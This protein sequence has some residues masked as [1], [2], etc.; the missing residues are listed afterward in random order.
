M[1]RQVVFIVLC[2]AFQPVLALEAPAGLHFDVNSYEVLGDNPLSPETIAK[3]LKPYLGRH[4]GLDGLSSAVEELERQLKQQGDSFHRVVVEPQSLRDGVVRLRMLEFKLGTIIVSG[5]KNFSAQ[6]IKQS[7]PS[8][9]TG[10]APNTRL[11]SQNLAIANEH[12]DKTMQMIFKEGEAQNTVDI[13]L[14]VADKSPHTRYAKLAN[15]G[16]EQTGEFR[17]GLGYQYSNLFDKDHIAS[18]NFSTSVE[19][20]ESVSQWVLSYSL[21]YYSRGDLLSFYLSDSAIDTIST[22]EGLAGNFNVNGS[23]RVIGTRYLQGFK[24]I[25]AY[26]QKVIY[27]FDYKTFNNQILFQGNPTAGTNELQ[28]VPLS[29]EYELSRAVAVSSFKLNVSLYQ[30]LIDDQD[31]YDLESRKPDSNWNLL[32]MKLKYD[33]PFGDYLLRL[34]MHGQYAAKPL[35]SAEQYGVGGSDSVRAYAER[36][37][38]GDRGY[39]MNIE[40]WSSAKNNKFNWLGFYDFAETT[41]IEDIGTGI[42]KQRPSSFGAGLRWRWK[43]NVSVSA[44]M[45][46]A[47]QDIGEIESGDA[48]LHLNMI[49]QY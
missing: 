37:V 36:T 14:Q 9:V 24:K 48:K 29:V 26:R 7:L 47:Q 6:N 49:Y 13:E 40:F 10:R 39:S 33:V 27:G 1:L 28:S 21:P 2:C 32:R 4:Y 3:I 11:L 8:L 19:Q 34:R 31:A 17:L 45:A 12:P 15:N 5:Q 46:V 25:K 22:A 43:R 44:D 38:L 42:L 18:I 23:G 35:I 16:S 20:P 30:N 41:F